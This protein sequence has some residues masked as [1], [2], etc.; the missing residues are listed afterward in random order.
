MRRQGRTLEI[1][2]EGAT[3]DTFLHHQ[4]KPFHA[5]RNVIWFFRFDFN[6][7]GEGT[8]RGKVIK[9]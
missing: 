8:F 6:F 3:G 4:K 5:Q 7:L 9:T 1:F 2:S